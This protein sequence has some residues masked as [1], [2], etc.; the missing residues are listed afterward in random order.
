MAQSQELAQVGVA[1]PILGEQHE[2]GTV[3]RQLGAYDRA[4]AQSAA[5]LL[6]PNRAVDAVDIGKC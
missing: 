5:G 1:V 6:E 4:D 2:R 3:K